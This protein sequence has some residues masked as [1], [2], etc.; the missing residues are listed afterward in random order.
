MG[1]SNFTL[2]PIISP[3]AALTR[4]FLH[5]VGIPEAEDCLSLQKGGDEHGSY[6]TDDNCTHAYVG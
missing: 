6:G 2:S 3:G 4:K 5:A 1:N